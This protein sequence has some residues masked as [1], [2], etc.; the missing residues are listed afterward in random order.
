MTSLPSWPKPFWLLGCGNMAGAMLSRWLDCGLDP[1]TVTVIRPSGRPVAPGV[2]VLT[3][4][5]EGEGPP[6]ALMLGVKPQMLGSVTA[7]VG[8]V[9]GPETLLLSI[10][11]GVEAGTLRAHFPVPRSIVRAMP[12]T[13]VAIG[14]GVVALYAERPA[15]EIDDLMNPLGLVEWFDDETSFARFTTVSG[16]GP[17]FLFRFID[18]LADAAVGAGVSA[19]R[20]ARVALATVEGAAALAASSDADPATLAERVASPGG[21]TRAGLNVLDADGA[22]GDLIRRTIEAAQR[23]SAEI[24]QA[25]RVGIE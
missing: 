23:R 6:G 7:E 8:R 20:A 24:T 12:N 16:C 21:T 1:A 9:L 4:L 5:P 18:A 2:R 11:A 19:D 3:A 10:M 22:L 14:K 25:A 17:A 13:P 15:R